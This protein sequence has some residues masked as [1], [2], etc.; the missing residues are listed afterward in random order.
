[1]IAASAFAMGAFAFEVGVQ[2]AQIAPVADVVETSPPEPV[3]ATRSDANSVMQAGDSDASNTG[4]SADGPIIVLVIDD[5]GVDADNSARAINLNQP[6]TISILPYADNASGL[7]AMARM[8]GHETFIHLPM[9]PEGLADPG[10]HALTRHLSAEDTRARVRWAIEQIPGATGLNNHMGSAVTQD[11]ARMRTILLPLA[12]RDLMFLDSLTAPDSR[13][14]AVARDLGLTALRRDTFIDHEN[15]AGA[16]MDRLSEIERH[17]ERNGFVIAIGHPRD[18]TMDALEVWIP[19]AVSRGYRF[20]TVSQLVEMQSRA[21]VRSAA[22]GEI[23]S[24]GGGAK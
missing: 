1:M 2:S 4:I 17:A 12:G 24:L 6:V 15:S 22:L 11:A 8:R 9:E 7:D 16:I 19:D 20:V 21:P 18:L 23:M 14:F 5:V 10:P 3:G 13:A